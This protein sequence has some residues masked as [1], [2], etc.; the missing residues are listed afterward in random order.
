MTPARRHTY[1]GLFSLALVLLALGPLRRVVAFSMDYEN[2]D[3]SHVLLIPFISGALLFS[4]RYAIFS[5]LRSSILP[6]GILIIIGAVLHY[7][8]RTH[9]TQLGKSDYLAL[10]AG[11]VIVAWLGGFFLFYGSAAF[12]AGLFPLLFLGLAIPI[13]SRVFHEFARMLQNGSASMVA[14]LFTLTGT[15]TYR[16]DVVFALPGLTIEVAEECSG[17]RSTLGIL[18]ISLLAGHLLLKSNWRKSAFLLAVVPISLF[19]N[20]VRIVTLSLLAI[21]WDMSFIT[22][23]LHHDGGIVFMMIGLGLMYPFLVLLIKSEEKNLAS[24]VRS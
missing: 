24:G 3:S 13:P 23:R 8:G 11:S 7:I 5:D 2:V 15:P 20:A 14:V 18:I 4:R 22:G 19:K 21:Y 12:K 17:I 10:I 9:E 16:N 6:A 1:F